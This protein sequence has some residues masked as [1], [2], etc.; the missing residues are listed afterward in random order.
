MRAASPFSTLR[1]AMITFEALRRTKC[2]AASLPK[3]VY[4]VWSFSAIFMSSERSLKDAGT[5]IRT[6]YDDGFA[7]AVCCRYRRCNEEL[8]V[9]ECGHEVEEDVRYAHLEDSIGYRA[10]CNACRCAWGVGV[11]TSSF[12]MVVRVRSNAAPICGLYIAPIQTRRRTAV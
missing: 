1:H 11:F 4:L 2:L 5:Y 6:S 9:E 3:P 7:G 8:G 12:A 10:R